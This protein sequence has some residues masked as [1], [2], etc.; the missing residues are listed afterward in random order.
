MSRSVRLTMFLCFTFVILVLSPSIPYVHATT[1]Y[2]PAVVPGNL[3]Q[4]AVLYDTCQSTDPMV[5]QSMGNGLNDT[6]YAALQVVDVSGPTVTLQLITVYKNG[7]GSHQG[8]SVNVDTG[9]SNITAMGQGPPGDYFVLAENLLVTDH[10]WNNPTAPIFNSTSSEMVLGTSRQVNFLNFSS[11]FSFG[12]SS[13]S[14]S[15]GFA[16]DQQSGVFV[17]I[18]F[19]YVTTGFAGDTTL[20]FAIGMVDNN[21]WGTA[22]LPDFDLSANPTTVDIVGSATGTSTISLTRSN[23]FAATVKLTATPSSSSITCSLSSNS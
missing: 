2:V 12:G 4:Y 21:I 5:C 17:E 6:Q 23:G 7:T 15:S 9:Q 20:K 3:A 19:Q 1:S 10:I 11:S 14:S 13:L 18:S 8:V 16:F 22:I